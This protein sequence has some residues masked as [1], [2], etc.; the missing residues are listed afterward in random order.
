[1]RKAAAAAGD[2]ERVHLWAGTGFRNATAEPAGV[3]LQRLAGSL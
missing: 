1:M 2:A 3:I